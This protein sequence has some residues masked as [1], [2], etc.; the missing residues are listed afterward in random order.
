MVDWAQMKIRLQ[1]HKPPMLALI[2]VPDASTNL[3]RP[4]WRYRLDF[5]LGE[6]I[7][8][9]S[10]P[11]PLEKPSHDD[12]EKWMDVVS[13]A[14]RRHREYAQKFGD[15]M[16]IVGKNSLGELRLQWEGETPLVT[17]ITASD[18]TFLV[19]FPEDYPQ[20]PFLVTIDNEIVK[21]GALN[22]DTGECSKVERSQRGTK[23][24][25][26][27]AGA[28]MKVFKTATQAQWWRRSSKANLAPLT[29][30]TISLSYD[31]PQFP[32]PK[33]PREPNT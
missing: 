3:P 14:Q 31:D 5:I 9:D 18:K 11:S 29:T 4:D 1:N 19:L 13:G 23:A 33:V 32:K 26:H 25:P 30:Y 6:G 10:S 27:V 28:V 2:D 7:P 15:G 20:A 16:E 21:V 12:F 8:S 24:A 22:R 17:N